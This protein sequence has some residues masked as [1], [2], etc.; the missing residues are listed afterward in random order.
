MLGTLNFLS[1]NKI[2]CTLKAGH[3]NYSEKWLQKGEVLL[4]QGGGNLGDLY[5]GPQALRER[6]ISKL[7]NNRIIILPQTIHFSSESNLEKCI[8][9]FS[10]H[11]DLHI[12]VRDE[13]SYFLA[14]RMSKNV[15]L[16]PDMAHQLWP[17]ERSSIPQKQS[18]GIIREDIESKNQPPLDV[19]L[20]TD[21]P[22]LIGN[23][24]RAFRLIQRIM[25][26]MHQAGADR[27]LVNLEMDLWIKYARKLSREAINLFSDYEN[28]ITDRLHGHI[29]SC[30]MNI[31]HTVHDNSYGKN[32]GYLQAWTGNSDI[33]SS[34]RAS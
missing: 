14:Q 5:P 9:I 6:V 2:P 27:Y 12:C 29:L 4:L 15:Y 33:V 18:L 30:L 19:D 11:K 25:G 34:H 13:N 1:Q 24:E 23:R 31:P 22:E 7:I 10:Q 8:G 17:V 28:I 16:L 32:S 20:K 21:W 3:F 26:T